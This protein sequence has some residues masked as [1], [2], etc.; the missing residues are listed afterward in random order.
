MI[1]QDD[2]TLVPGEGDSVTAT[3]TFDHPDVLKVV[4]R[5]IALEPHETNG[6]GPDG[7]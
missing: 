1:F 3:L 6:Q 7:E 4:C 5:K 2:V